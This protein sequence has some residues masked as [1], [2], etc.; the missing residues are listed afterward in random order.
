MVQKAM[1]KEVVVK[2]LFCLVVDI[3]CFIVRMLL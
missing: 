2:K 1:N 3:V